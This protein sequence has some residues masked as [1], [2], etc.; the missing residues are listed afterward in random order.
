MPKEFDLLSRKY[1]EDRSDPE[2]VHIDTLRAQARELRSKNNKL[3]AQI[4]E[5]DT[6]LAKEK[7]TAEKKA[8][9]TKN[10]QELLNETEAYRATLNGL[11][12]EIKTL[13]IAVDGHS[14]IGSSSPYEL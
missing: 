2:H 11:L 10:R 14:N 6:E 3:V 7:I 1:P 13:E 8:K 12:E 4:W 9:L 5:M